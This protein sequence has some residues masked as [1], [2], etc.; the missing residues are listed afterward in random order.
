MG[1]ESVPSR[2]IRVAVGR[3]E[4][5]DVESCKELDRSIELERSVSHRGKSD[6]IR[7]YLVPSGGGGKNLQALRHSWV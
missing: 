1:F 5:P 3:E 7:T 2:S 6:T 4:R